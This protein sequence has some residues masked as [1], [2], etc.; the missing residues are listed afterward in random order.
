MVSS[1]T[2]PEVCSGGWVL[3]GLSNP[4]QSY[5]KGVFIVQAGCGVPQSSLSQWYHASDC[6]AEGIWPVSYWISTFSF[7][8]LLS[9]SNFDSARSPAALVLS[10]AELSK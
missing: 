1:G 3:K 9:G 7:T 10:T 2:G 8:P 6:T 4:E 5:T